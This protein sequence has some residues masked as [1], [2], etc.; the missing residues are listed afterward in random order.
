MTS[1]REFA[2]LAYRSS[3]EERLA[4]PEFQAK[5]AELL[6]PNVPTKRASD[7]FTELLYSVQESE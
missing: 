6:K 5:L 4:S 2:I 7:L 1:P 3:V